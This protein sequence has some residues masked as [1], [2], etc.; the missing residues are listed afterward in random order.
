VPQTSLPRLLVS[1]LLAAST[2]AGAQTI[3]LAFDELE[4]WKTRAGREH[5][6]AYTEIV[7]ELARRLNVKLQIV[8]CPLK[9][10]LKL[11]EVGEAD[12]IIGVQPLAE[13]QGYVQ[14]L[15]TPYRRFSSDRVFL[16]RVGDTRRIDR[17][18]DLAGLH[19][20][21]T[22]GSG[23]FARFNTDKTLI[24]DAALNN[25]ASVRKLLLGRVDTALMPED[26]ALALLA[27]LGL[28]SKV[29]LAVFR[30]P[31]AT[32][33]FVGVSRRSVLMQRLPA[34]EQA[35]GQMREDGTLAKLYDT[36]YFQ[37]YRVARQR[38]QID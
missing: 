32:P 18:E 34:L 35:M 12:L 19:I 16:L 20:G 25:E 22:G 26:Q 33:R 8:D 24:K 4:P 27:Q 28:Q 31:D 38:L 21:V 29:E 2:S 7:R 37:R 30:E 6:G 5:T 36:H 14:F 13:R 10:C 3:R 17:Y 11:L 9:R 15:A 23:Y 1:A